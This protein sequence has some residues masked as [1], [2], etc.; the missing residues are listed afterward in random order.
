MK[1]IYRIYIYIWHVIGIKK[2]GGL[3]SAGLSKAKVG[4]GSSSPKTQPQQQQQ[5]VVTSPSVYIPKTRSLWIPTKGIV[6]IVFY[7]V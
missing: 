5:Q 1:V 2:I 3:A 7:V 6:L 4:F